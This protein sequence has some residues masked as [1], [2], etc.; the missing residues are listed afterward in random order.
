MFPGL[1]W[2]PGESRFDNLAI[3]VENV[4]D[5]GSLSSFDHKL[6]LVNLTSFVEVCVTYCFGLPDFQNT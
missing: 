4:V 2:V 1:L 5:P 6:E 3:S